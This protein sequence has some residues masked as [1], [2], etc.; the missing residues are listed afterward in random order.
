MV[1]KQIDN[2][3]Q[4]QNIP[5]REEQRSIQ[6]QSGT[7]QDYSLSV[8]LSETKNVKQLSGVRKKDQGSSVS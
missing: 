1:L 8:I 2:A 3:R 6:E 4:K 5:T 7:S